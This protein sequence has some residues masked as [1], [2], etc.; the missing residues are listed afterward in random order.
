MAG[1]VNDEAFVPSLQVLRA[2]AALSVVL[3]HVSAGLPASGILETAKSICRYGFVGVDIF[4]VLSGYVV[5]KAVWRLRTSADVRTFVWRRLGRIYGGYWPVLLLVLVLQCGGVPAAHP[6]G[7]WLTSI[8][9]VEPLMDRNVLP[10]AHTLVYEMWFYVAIAA[11]AF[12]LRGSAQRRLALIFAATGLILWQAIWILFDFS[13][14][15]QARVPLS[16]ALSALYLEFLAGALIYALRDAGKIRA[17]PAAG[18]TLWLLG[19][20]VLI[21]SWEF[22]GLTLIRA[23]VGGTVGVGA[24]LVALSVH[25]NRGPD[26]RKGFWE[27]LGDASY[28]LYLLHTV[29]LATVATLASRMVTRGEPFVE[30]AIAATAIALS[31]LAARLWYR[32][33]E[34][35]V[36]LWWCAQ[37]S[38]RSQSA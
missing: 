4:F 35:P 36:Y 9:L 3:F 20:A 19:V 21:P 10:V 29:V 13:A 25:A 6:G 27:R 2:V 11:L 5:A 15:R 14:W 38:N 7:N 32:R 18:P 16:F 34:K 8:L 1:A 24:L 28:S 26:S 31:V 37:V 12:S 22:F 23:I 17:N 33:L 30:C